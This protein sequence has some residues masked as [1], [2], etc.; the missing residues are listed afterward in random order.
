MLN[1]LARHFSRLKGE[2]ELATVSSMNAGVSDVSQQLFKALDTNGDQRISLDEFRNLLDVLIGDTGMGKKSGALGPGSTA[3]K[4]RGPVVRAQATPAPATPDG[5][6]SIQGFDFTKL[7]NTSYQSPKYSP[8]VRAFSQA[9]FALNPSAAASRDH[10]E[11]LVEAVKQ[12]GFPNAAAVGDDK[13][14]FGDGVGPI[15]VITSSDQ[16]WFG[17]PF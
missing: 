11:P 14:D 8:A 3:N 12:R 17:Q 4:A 1:T 9:L 6:A 10:L 16:W 13:I 15:D 5:F 7:T 2:D